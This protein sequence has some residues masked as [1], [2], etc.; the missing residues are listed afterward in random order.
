[1]FD[2]KLFLVQITPSGQVLPLDAERNLKS[3]LLLNLDF[4]GGHLK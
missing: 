1:M 2:R 4:K 3:C